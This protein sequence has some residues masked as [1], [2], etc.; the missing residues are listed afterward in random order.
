VRLWS[1]AS[2]PADAAVPLL[3]AHDG[4]GLAESASLLS[5]ASA[6][7]A[8]DPIRVALLDPAPGCRDSWYSANPGYLHHLNDVVLP[9][10]RGQ[11]KVSAVVGLGV[12]L[13]A[14]AMITWQRRH[15][16]AVDALAL[17]S[18]SFFTPVLDPQESGFRY[19]DRIYAAVLDVTARP[20]ERRV[21][22]LL[23]CGAIEE[24]LA[25]NQLMAEE[26][27]AAGDPTTFVT[28]PDAHNTIGWRDAWAPHLDRLV[29][30]V[31]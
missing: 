8:A 14:V 22:L 12:S 10:L 6:H 5:W 9:A 29:D 31:S 26:L 3:I 2:L 28:V 20:P 18:G 4:S 24:N 19:F 25:N 30:A 17:Q 16:T 27:T 11:V 13:G 1:P 7:A 23:T 15:P 21:P